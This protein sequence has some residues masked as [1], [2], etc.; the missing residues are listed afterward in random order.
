MGVEQRLVGLLRIGPENEG[1]AV[2][3]LEV[4]A[5]QF[6]PLAADDR[7]IFRPVELERLARQE[8]SGTNAPRPHVFCSCCRAA[9]QSRAKAATRLYEPS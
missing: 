5:L 9:L 6:G 8:A 4:S 2:A 1:A 3:E 7:P